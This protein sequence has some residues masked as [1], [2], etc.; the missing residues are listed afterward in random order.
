MDMIIQII[1]AEIIHIHSRNQVI[2]RLNSPQPQGQQ[3]LTEVKRP[4]LK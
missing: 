2:I 4:Y 3:V 1:Q